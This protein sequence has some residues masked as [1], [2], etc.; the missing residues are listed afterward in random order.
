MCCDGCDHQWRADF[1]M[2]PA[3]CSDVRKPAPYMRLKA[4]MVPNARITPPAAPLPSVPK[5]RKP[6]RASDDDESYADRAIQADQDRAA[7][8]R[9]P[10][11]DWLLPPP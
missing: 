4:H 1:E 6:K 9:N 7:G 8:I 5:L 2:L 11:Q 3:W 10:D